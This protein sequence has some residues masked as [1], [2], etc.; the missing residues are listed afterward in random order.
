MDGKSPCLSLTRAQ[1]LPLQA[2]ARAFSLSLSHTH[3]GTWHCGAQGA[4]RQYPLSHAADAHMASL[5]EEEVAW[6]V[7][8]VVSFR[9][10]SWVDGESTRSRA[11]LDKRAHALLPPSHIIH[12]L[13]RALCRTHEASPDSKLPFKSMIEHSHTRAH[14]HT[15]YDPTS[16]HATRKTLLVG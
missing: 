5:E 15:Q 13:E 8:V 6:V 3:T 11:M 1:A 14:T 9:Q 12:S 2:R 7:S 4:D 10:G 16:M